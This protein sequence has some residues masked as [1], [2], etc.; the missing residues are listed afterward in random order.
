MN[1]LADTHIVLWALKNDTT[2]P[3][4]ARNLL[5]DAENDIY[6]SVAS[7]WEIEIKHGIR[8]EQIKLNGRQSVSFCEKAGYR[9]LP[10]RREHIFLL[11]T[12]QRR[13]DAPVHK[14]PFDRILIAQAKCEQ[15]VFLTHDA[16]MRGYNEKC[17]R[18][19]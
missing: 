15:M 5:T 11:E 10:V 19:V 13:T 14:D 18:I 17:I 2:L 12:L 8:P 3:F 16:M 6:Y 1:I 7:I 4:E 9:E